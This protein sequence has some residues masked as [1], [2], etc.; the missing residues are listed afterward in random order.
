MRVA[1]DS[2]AEQAGLRRGD[3]ILRIDD[4]EVASLET[5]YK[6]LWRDGAERHVRLDVLRGGV[7][8]RLTARTLDRMKTLR[9]PQG[10]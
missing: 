1:R 5:F 9:R 2:P 8:R 4:T 10:I 7:A 6:A 3:R